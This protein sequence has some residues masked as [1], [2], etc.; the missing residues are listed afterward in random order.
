MYLLGDIGGTKTRLIWCESEKDLRKQ[1]LKIFI[2]PQKYRE[3]LELLK[4]FINSSKTQI[5]CEQN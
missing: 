1:K 2:T 4:D 3:F 5:E